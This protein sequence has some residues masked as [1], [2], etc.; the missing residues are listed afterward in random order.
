MLI[1]W[2]NC[3]MLDQI[4]I[5]KIQVF[6]LPSLISSSR[7]FIFL[8]RPEFLTYMYFPSLLRS[9]FRFFFFFLARLLATNSL[10]FGFWL[11]LESLYSLVL[12]DNFAGYRFWVGGVFSLNI[13]TISLDSVFDCVVSKER[14]DVIL[15][16]V[17]L[18][19]RCFPLWLL[20]GFYPWFCVVWKWY[21]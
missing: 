20:S 2:T 18:E 5:S 7:L 19:V 9:S 6:I 13:V 17:P 4:K 16:S 14:S 3:C 11:V 12:K 15:I 8:C 10:N 1:F 21:T